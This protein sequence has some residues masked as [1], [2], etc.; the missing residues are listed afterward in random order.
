MSDTVIKGNFCRNA[1][2]QLMLMEIISVTDRRKNRSVEELQY[3]SST[4][5]AILRSQLA[6]IRGLPVRDGILV[7]VMIMSQLAQIRGL[8]AYESPRELADE[9]S[10]LAQIRGLPG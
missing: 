2:E 8:P 9:S 5:C 1:P 7:T 10:Q 3:K 6:Q 4:F